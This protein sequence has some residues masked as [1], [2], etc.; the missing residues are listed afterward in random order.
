MTADPTWVKVAD[1]ADLPEGR[2]MTVTVGRRSGQARTTP[3]F[4]LRDGENLVLVASR[5]G[6]SRHPDWYQNIERTP[7]VTV[8]VANETRAMLARPATEEETQEL[9]PKLVAMF[10]VWERFQQRS[11]RSF[12]VVILSP[13]DEV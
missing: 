6:T 5:G 9:W 10:S 11:S 12:P 3:L 4:Y 7:E 2:V 8:Q 1:L 13:T